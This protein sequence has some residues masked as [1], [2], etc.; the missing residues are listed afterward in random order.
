MYFYDMSKYAFLVSVV[1]CF[2]FFGINT[3]TAQQKDSENTNTLIQP[4]YLKI[5]DTVAIVAP[6][7]ILINREDEVDQAKALLQKLGIECDCW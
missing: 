6:S 2:I 3:A 4:P 5:G 1:C 7:G